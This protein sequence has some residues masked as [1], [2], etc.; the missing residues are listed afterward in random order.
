MS[1]KNAIRH[2]N[3]DHADVLISYVK[4]YKNKYNVE[5]VILKEILEDRIIVVVDDTEE[6]EI[7]TKEKITS[8]NVAKVF[9][10]MAQE[11]K[12]NLQLNEDKDLIIKE[13]IIA[14]M[15]SL[16]T[17]SLATVGVNNIP[18]ISYAPY[19]NYA[20]N[21]YI[22]ISQI[23][24]HYK[25]LE[26]NKNL[27]IMFIED[28]LAAKIM[29]AR[30]RVTFQCDAEILNRD[31]KEFDQILNLMAQKVD[32]NIEFTKQLGDFR[33]VKLKFNQGKYIHGI[34]KAYNIDI[35]NNNLDYPSFKVKRITKDAHIYMK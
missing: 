1:F 7:L 28:E 5:K 14:L 11:S 30:K 23:A 3:D 12:S 29:I 15:N 13:K 27:E 24:D 17:V 35:I 8:N 18:T 26:V 25:N 22:Y 10:E 32:K 33:L 34:G 20:N 2:M 31:I 4:Y 19:I 21:H 9:I 6:I 16:K